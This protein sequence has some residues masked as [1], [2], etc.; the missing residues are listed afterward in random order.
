MTQKQ[1]LFCE[2]YLAN[3]YNALAAYH[4]VF[5][6]PQNKKPSYP[7]TL[8][9]TP[10]IREYIDSRRKEMYEG[11]NIDSMRIISE[12]AEMAFASKGDETYNAS[13]KLKA[14]EQLSKD[15]GLQTTKIET[16]DTIEVALVEDE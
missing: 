1:T 12:L 15:L 13:I 4:A 9:K 2:T 6:H 16:T 11:L 3:G 5:G 10:E 8:L 14:L 7:Y